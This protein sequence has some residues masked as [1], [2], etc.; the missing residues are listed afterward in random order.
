MSQLF[1]SI[2]VDPRNCRKSMHVLHQIFTKVNDCTCR[3]NTMM[4]EIGVKF[5]GEKNLLAFA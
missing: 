2:M 5:L 4:M 1:P 3:K